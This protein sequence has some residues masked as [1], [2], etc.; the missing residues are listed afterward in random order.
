[1]TSENPHSAVLA[2]VDAV[3]F[4][5]DGTL[6]DSTQ[7]VD[8]L[9][10][11]LA[12]RY[13]IDPTALLDYAHGRQ[14]GDTIGRFLSPA[15]DPEV[16]TRRFE[17]RELVETRGITEIPGARRLLDRLPAERVAVVT[18]A[19]RALAGLRLTAAGLELPQVLV[20]GDE[21]TRGK[22]DP[23][24]YAEAARR[25]GVPIGQCL[26]VEDAEAGILAGCA[27]GAQVL[28][29]GSHHSETTRPL[30]RVEDLTQ[31]SVD[32]SGGRIRLVRA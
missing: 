32:T 16:V 12:R 1:M 22:P 21:V 10:A 17:A 5:M 24:G 31:L 11:E 13:G 18:S 14:T 25:L 23:E 15:D 9:W 20:P 8:G 6:V 4:D 2:E 30:P 19:P 27:S 3:L 29:V 26:V 28:V 7:V